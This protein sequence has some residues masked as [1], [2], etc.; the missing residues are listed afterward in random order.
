MAEDVSDQITEE[1]LL[2]EAPVSEALAEA[3]AERKKRLKADYEK[4]TK[5]VADCE[6]E[7]VRLKEEVRK[8]TK[9]FTSYAEVRIPLHEM[10]RRQR[11][12]TRGE[13]EQRAKVRELLSNLPAGQK[14]GV[15]RRPPLFNT[16][17]SKKE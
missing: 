1:E 17:A 12:I 3:P 14:T 4:A 7:L 11:E 9:A 2:G 10:N 8:A 16:G 13:T 15:P 6:K 5:A